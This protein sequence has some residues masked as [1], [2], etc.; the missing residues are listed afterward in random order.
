MNMKKKIVFINPSS[1]SSNSLLSTGSWQIAPLS[2]AYLISYTDLNVWDV[3]VLDEVFDE[4]EILETDV[5]AITAMTFT[6]NRAYEIA[7]L[8]KKRGIYV[9]MGGY[10]PTF[11][12][13]EVLNYA[14]TVITGEAE[15]IWPT[16][17]NDFLINS[18][19][20]VYN[21]TIVDLNTIKIPSHNF[22]SNKYPTITVQTSRGCPF[23]CSFCTVSKM[24]GL[25]YRQRTIDSIITELKSTDKENIVFIDDNIIGVSKNHYSRAAQL[26][27]RMIDE[28]VN[29]RWVGFTSLNIVDNPELLALANKSGCF[30]LNIGIESESISALKD[31]KKTQNVK[32]LDKYTIEQAVDIIHKQGISVYSTL[33]FGF[34]SDTKKDLRHRIRFIKNSNIDVIAISPLTPLPGSDLYI[35]ANANDSIIYNDFPKDWNRFSVVE[36]TMNTKHLNAS[37]INRYLQKAFRIMFNKSK[38]KSKFKNTK[39]AVKDNKTAESCRMLN[40]SFRRLYL[41]KK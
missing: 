12:L 4:F 15:N 19:K 37:D 28:K 34:Q 6:I 27:Q 35:D 13:D 38:I 10:H 18:P 40:E 24:A 16:F 22:I 29:K 33:I 30:M 39:K 7:Q 23:N 41:H 20:R 2:I 17:L 11:M 3:V 5:V 32:V 26:F 31:A 36:A 8:Y 14:D 1:E 25:K 9:V 21:G